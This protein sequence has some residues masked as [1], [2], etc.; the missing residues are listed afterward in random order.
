MEDLGG[1]VSATV[2]FLQQLRDVAC[3][4]SESGTCSHGQ[5]TSS[6]VNQQNPVLHSTGDH[7]VAHSI[8]EDEKDHP[9]EESTKLQSQGP[10]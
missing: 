9:F 2:H 10:K 6:Q 4:G 1:V 7:Q 5:A 8:F 3:D